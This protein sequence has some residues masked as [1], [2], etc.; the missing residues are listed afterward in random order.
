MMK[1]QVNL[2]FQ[3]VVYIYIYTNCHVEDVKF[4]KI[5]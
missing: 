5:L 1:F 2:E 3:M 4:Q